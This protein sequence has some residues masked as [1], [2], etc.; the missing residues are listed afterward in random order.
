M[1][2]TQ[3]APDLARETSALEAAVL[4]AVR[5]ERV[6]GLKHQLEV[7]EVMSAYI[8]AELLAESIDL[9]QL[10]EDRSVAMATE[11]DD[12]RGVNIRLQEN[13]RA[14][15]KAI[16]DLA[17]ANTVHEEKVSIQAQ[18]IL[19]LERELKSV[20]SILPKYSPAVE[21]DNSEVAPLVPYKRAAD[22]SLRPRMRK[23]LFKKI[24]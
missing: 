5:K 3:E 9:E 15:H 2:G 18:T 14:A 8:K 1:S 19:R 16:F 11:S 10:K 4:V 22:S 17:A 20:T 23:D 24:L 12:L 7:W 21:I 13:E 6:R